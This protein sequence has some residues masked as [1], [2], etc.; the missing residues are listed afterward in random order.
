MLKKVYVVELESGH[1]LEGYT[2]YE[3]G[4]CKIDKCVKGVIVK[5]PI[6]EG[7]KPAKLFTYIVS[8]D[9]IFENHK[10]AYEYLKRVGG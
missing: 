6:S 1:I 7:D 10:D 3:K 4:V 5:F 2:K 9:K 8:E